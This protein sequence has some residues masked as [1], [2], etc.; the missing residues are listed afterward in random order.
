MILFEDT[1]NQIG[2][3]KR[4]NA[5]LEKLGHTVERTKLYVGDYADASN[6]KVYVDTKKD[7]VE[8][9]GNICGKQHE[10]FRN[11]CLRAQNMGYKLVFLKYLLTSGN[12]L[13]SEMASLYAMFERQPYKKQCKL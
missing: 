6:M 10:R 2:K 3:H 13:E 4:L 12:R 9:A 1:R 7:W 8:L 11:E 5:D